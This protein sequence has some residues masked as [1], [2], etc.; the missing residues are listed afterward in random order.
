MFLRRRFLARERDRCDDDDDKLDN[1]ARETPV[2]NTLNL[3]DKRQRSGTPLRIDTAK[4][5][6]FISEAAGSPRSGRTVEYAATF[7]G[8]RRTWGPP[9]T[10]GGDGHGRPH[11]VADSAAGTGTSTASA[12]RGLRDTQRA[13]T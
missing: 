9:L 2:E 6:G 12:S 1:S 11:P 10:G 4:V 5:G 7:G 3:L 8:P 13:T